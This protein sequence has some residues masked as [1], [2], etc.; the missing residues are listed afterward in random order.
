MKVTTLGKKY[1]INCGA[2]GNIF[3]NTLGTWL[4]QK[5]QKITFPLPFSHQRKKRWPPLDVHV[6]WSHWLHENYIPKPVCHHFWP[7]LIW[8][9]TSVGTYYSYNGLPPFMA[10]HVS[11]YLLE[12][13]VL[14]RMFQ[15]IIKQLKKTRV[16][17]R[18]LASIRASPMVLSMDS[19]IKWLK[20]SCFA[21]LATP[22]Q[23]WNCICV[24]DHMCGWLLI[25]NHL[26]Q[27]LWST[28]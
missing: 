16:F 22:P 1:G 19:K 28:N 9:P 15:P 3:G 20:F 18:H 25:A 6:E 4:E 17:G 7:S 27:S 14:F 10:I 26:D 23:N 24:G 11:T 5:I 2:L 8:L 12:R 21:F 13:R